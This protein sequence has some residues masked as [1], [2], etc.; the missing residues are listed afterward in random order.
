MVTH[1]I[2]RVEFELVVSEAELGRRVSD[3]VSVLHG[4]R[5]SGVIDRVCTEIDDSDVIDRI[6]TLE[7]ELG[8]VEL[9]RFDDDLCAKLEAALREALRGRPR[10][11]DEHRAEARVED[12]FA[13]NETIDVPSGPGRAGDARELLDLYAWTGNL[14]WWADA[15]EPDLVAL[16]VRELLVHAPA[17]WIEL[18]REHAEDRAGLDRLTRACSDELF[19]LIVA[20]A[21][22]VEALADLRVLDRLLATIGIRRERSRASL[23]AAIGRHGRLEVP[24]VLPA[25]LREL[26]TDVI[27]AVAEQL[28][29]TTEP[30]MVSLHAAIAQARSRSAR[31][32]TPTQSDEPREHDDTQEAVRAEAEPT[33]SPTGSAE[34]AS[35]LAP[36]ASATPAEESLALPHPEPPA[37]LDPTSLQSHPHPADALPQHPRPA[38][39]DE[40]RLQLARRRALAR[41]D[42]LYIDDA[43]LVIL[44]PFLERLFTRLDLLEKR[45]FRD[46]AAQ[47]QAIA[48]LAYLAHEDPEP[49]EHRLAFAKLLCGRPPEHPCPLDAPLAHELRDECDTLLA[50]VIDHAPVL[51][52]M[53]ISRF[54]ASFLQRAGGLAVRTGSWLLAVERQPWDVILD[55]F[56][57]S[58][59]WIKLPWMPEPVTVEW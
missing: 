29:E 18:L 27:A 53:P 10:R 48:L 49:P 47:T 19:E 40:P 36:D 57:W 50:A 16:R 20:R 34:Q 44:W 59:A 2:N 56:S 21:G 42:E 45:F 22:A 7:L 52:A 46:E 1:R 32:T 23:L 31:H 26:D 30:G 8:V 11:I 15:S 17:S 58:W 43:G 13:E 37:Q 3:R 9:E 39:P 5:I 25:V 6:E 12:G 51:D 14:P 38:S 24:E 54:R 28:G 55:R 41:L 35:A 4:S 33:A